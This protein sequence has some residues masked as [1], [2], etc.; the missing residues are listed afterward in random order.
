M[1]GNQ[2]SQR[3]PNTCHFEGVGQPVVDEYAA[4]QWKNLCLVLKPPERGRE[5]DPV[6][7]ALKG[8]TDVF[9]I[10]NIPVFQS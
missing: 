10:L 9:S 8:G 3:T 7:I 5:N 1:N 6:V 4:G 2:V